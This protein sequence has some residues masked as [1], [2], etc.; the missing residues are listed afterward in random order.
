MG[1]NR[2]VVGSTSVLEAPPL[3]LKLNFYIKFFYVNVK[4]IGLIICKINPDNANITIPIIPLIILLCASVT[5]CVS[6]HAA[7]TLIPQTIIIITENKTPIVKTNLN[8]GCK[9]A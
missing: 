2:L 1:S 3:I 9:Y 6:S 5:A 8:N 7:I 4:N